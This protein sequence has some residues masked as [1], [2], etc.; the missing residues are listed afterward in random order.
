MLNEQM[1]H[2]LI[3]GHS[4]PTKFM[5]DIHMVYQWDSNG[6]ISGLEYWSSMHESHW[7]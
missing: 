5:K 4:G 6:N 1:V 2:E 7:P 3:I